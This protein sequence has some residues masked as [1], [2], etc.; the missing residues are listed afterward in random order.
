MFI[1]MGSAYEDKETNGLSHFLEHVLLRGSAD[2]DNSLEF[3][4]ALENFGAF[5]RGETFREF[6]YLRLTFLSQHHIDKA[7]AIFSEVFKNPRFNQEEME[8]ERKRILEEILEYQDAE[9]QDIDVDE[10]ASALLWPDHP[11]GLKIQGE[12]ENIRRFKL[13][14]I[15]SHFQKFIRPNNILLSL[16]GDFKDQDKL[17]KIAEEKLSFLLSPEISGSKNTGS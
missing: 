8:V 4:E 5:L 11:L 12:K 9:G 14:D 10:I 2:Y 1:K 15:E 16:V 13:S 7:L 6:T 3:R 17:Q